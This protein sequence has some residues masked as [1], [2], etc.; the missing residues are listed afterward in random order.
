MF[1]RSTSRWTHLQHVSSRCVSWQSALDIMLS[2]SVIRV[3]SLFGQRERLTGR[4][5]SDLHSVVIF[6][7]SCIPAARCVRKICNNRSREV[8]Y[9]VRLSD[10]PKLFEALPVWSMSEVVGDKSTDLLIPKNL[11]IGFGISTLSSMEREI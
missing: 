2:F 11:A 6:W 4:L 1:P 3:A 9:R 10:N 7:R 5:P 8:I